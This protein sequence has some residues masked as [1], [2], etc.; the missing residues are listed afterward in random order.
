[1]NKKPH[2]DEDAV[3]NVCIK[4][5]DYLVVAEGPNEEEY[6]FEAQDE[7]RKI[8][9]DWLEENSITCE[10]NKPHKGDL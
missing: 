9:Q 4:I 8:I 1:M 10:S 2:L 6:N 7:L 3:T 5:M